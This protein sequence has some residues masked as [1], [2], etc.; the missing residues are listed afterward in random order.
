[1]SGEGEKTP[2]SFT[3]QSSRL[4]YRGW[5]FS[6]VFESTTWGL[7]VSCGR[8]P[9]LLSSRAGPWPASGCVWRGRVPGH[10]STTAALCRQAALRSSDLILIPGWWADA[11]VSPQMVAVVHVEKANPY[12]ESVSSPVGVEHCLS[13]VEGV[14][15][16]D[17]L[18]GGWLDFSPELSAGLCCWQ[19]GLLRR[20]WLTS[21]G[22]WVSTL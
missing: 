17:V 19:V 8:V 5:D 18:G 12:P 15:P 11:S 10:M 21:P 7:A 4:L 2:L 14:P 13:R 1:M 6:Q 22:G 16:T 3:R 9:S 20:S